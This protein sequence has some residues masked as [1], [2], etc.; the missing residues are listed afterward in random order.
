LVRKE[1]F[2][3]SGTVETSEKTQLTASFYQQDTNSLYLS[4]AETT[5]VGFYSLNGSAPY[6]QLFSIDFASPVVSFTAYQANPVY[7]VALSLNGELSII[8]T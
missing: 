2:S 7:M 5:L 8:N 4:F 1:D 3:V 6:T